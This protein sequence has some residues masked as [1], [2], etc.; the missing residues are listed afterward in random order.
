MK[1]QVADTS[2][3]A[4]LSTRT[5]AETQSE[6]I[7][8]YLR[9]HPDGAVHTE[10][11]EVYGWANNTSSRRLVDLRARGMV[12]WADET[13]PTRTGRRAHVYVIVPNVA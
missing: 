5:I 10:I 11:D 6:M 4:F 2:M 7:L 13:R 1:Y 8:D 3:E 12:T 9:A